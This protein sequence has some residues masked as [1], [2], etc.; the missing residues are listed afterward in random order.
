MLELGLDGQRLFVY[1]ALAFYQ[2]QLFRK[3]IYARTGLG[4]VWGWA[5]ALGF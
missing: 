5:G 4:V 3:R 1:R 2:P